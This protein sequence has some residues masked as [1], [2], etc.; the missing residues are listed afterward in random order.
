MVAGMTSSTVKAGF[1]AVLATGLHVDNFPHYT[2]CDSGLATDS[3]MPSASSST[4]F[5]QDV[6]DYGGTP[7]WPI[8]DKIIPQS[9]SRTSLHHQHP[10]RVL[11]EAFDVLP[12][13]T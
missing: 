11:L 1:T 8:S 13:Q 10:H 2:Y 7:F 12:K 4:A 6:D 9:Q 5:E 3:F